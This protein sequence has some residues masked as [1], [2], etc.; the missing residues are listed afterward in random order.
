[1]KNLSDFDAV[2]RTPG[3]PY[4]LKEIQRAVRKGVNVTSGT[5]VFLA[6]A[7]GTVIGVTGTK[8]KGTTVSLI[9]EVLKVAGWDVHMAG[10]IGKPALDLI[11]KLHKN[12]ITVLELS[13]FQLQGINQSPHIAVVLDIFPDH[14]DAHKNFRE[15][16]DA[17]SN[18]TSHQ[19]PSDLVF[20]MPGNKYSADIAGMSAGKKIAVP[21]ASF[22]IDL[23]IPGA[24]NVKNAAMAAAVVSH[25]GVSPVTT[26][27]TI[28]SFR[29]LPFRLQLTR[30][31]GGI[32]IYND[33]ASTNPQTIVAALT[34]FPGKAKI[35]I[36]G[37]RD[38]GLDYKP[39]AD[40]VSREDVG[41]VVLFGENRA[42]IKKVIGS[43][44]KIHNSTNILR[45]VDSAM[46]LSNPGDIIIFSPGASSFDM[47]TSYIERG[48]EFDRIVKNLKN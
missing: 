36:A 34:S 8:G 25:F 10:N 19:K 4:N 14:L 46:K 2:Y 20:Y 47:F 38:K 35:L 11:P 1:V 9:H 32:S 5:E 6:G 26:I 13:S 28:S 12:S 15:Y 7:R 16:V 22:P 43:R 31:I 41:A 18:I 39:V 21:L 37:G 24:H 17:K 40:A 3:V 48:K 23:K 44:V 33:S 27:G 42:K 45:A 30:K 29:G